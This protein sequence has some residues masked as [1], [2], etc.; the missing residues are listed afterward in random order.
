M[1]L[2]AVAMTAP[3]VALVGLE[4]EYQLRRDGQAV[5]FRDLIH[6]LAV[7]GRRLD[8]GDTNAY[9]CP[10]GMALTCDEAEAEVASPPLALAPGFTAQ[11]DAWAHAG[12]RLL[13][14]LLPADVALLGFSSHLSVA[15][16]DR[17]ADRVLAVLAG[18]F[19]PALMMVLDRAGSHGVFLR[20]RPSRMELCGEYAIGARLQAAAALFA[21]AVRA[22]AGGGPVPPALAITP[23]PAGGRVG[24]ELDRHLAF[25]FDLYRDGRAATLPAAGGGTID[26]QR[27]LEL[28][29]GCARAALAG[30]AGPEDLEAMDR[31]VAGTSPLGIE[32]AE[33]D[34]GS[35]T[36]IASTPFGDLLVAR[37]RGDVEV[38]PFLAT[39]GFT[40]FSVRGT[41]GSRYACIPRASLAAFLDRLDAGGLDGWLA[42]APSSGRILA[43]AGQTGRPGLWDAVGDPTDLLPPERTPSQPATS[44]GARH[45]KPLVPPASAPAA[46]LPEPV[47][48]PRGPVALLIAVVLT[49]LLVGAAFA[50]G[51]FGAGGE[52]AV[53]TV[54]EAPVASTTTAPVTTTT[55]TTLA[56]TTSAPAVTVPQPAPTVVAP[57]TTAP[58]VAPSPTTT[59]TAPTTTLAPVTTTTTAVPGPVTLT[60]GLGCTLSPASSSRPVGS[61]VRVA[62]QSGGE[63][64]VTVTGPPG[65]SGARFSL[66]AGGTSAAYVLDP[67]GDYAFRCVAGGAAGQA[68]LRAT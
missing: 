48:R 52:E 7:P 44:R 43:G 56:A 26:G 61:A 13:G 49:V 53:P 10:S 63:I 54:V 39:W 55:S 14:D 12:R 66:D 31:I 42:A 5:D 4:H 37:R 29:W 35:G 38:A 50:S 45:G 25:G 30:N 3:A 2:A 68:V 51:L 57:A 58:T 1:G 21:G 60:V 28:S 65:S 47:R 36:E 17:D 22:A 23:H 62:N 32:A 64:G 8:P 33:N 15:V 27:H 20:P 40:V 18:S 16:A 24:L 59:A 6:G 19:G 46:A 41:G 9:R 34:V 67:A 11:V